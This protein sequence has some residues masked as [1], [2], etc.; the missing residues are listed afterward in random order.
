MLNACS[1]IVHTT[2]DNAVFIRVPVANWCGMPLGCVTVSRLLLRNTN[3]GV[4]IPTGTGG[5]RRLQVNTYRSHSSSQL[6]QVHSWWLCVTEQ[7]TLTVC[8]YEMFVPL[9]SCLRTPREGLGLGLGS[10]NCDIGSATTIH[11]W[12]G[13]V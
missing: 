7:G 5:G 6:G 13:E 8:V 10:Q 9:Y 1:S 11:L 2:T 4:H 3:S 12:S